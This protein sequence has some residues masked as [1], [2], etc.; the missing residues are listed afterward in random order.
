VENR[1]WAD[2]FDGHPGSPDYVHSRQAVAEGRATLRTLCGEAGQP[3]TVIMEVQGQWTRYAPS[4]SDRIIYDRPKTPAGG[5]PA[6]A[7]ETTS[8]PLAL[9]TQKE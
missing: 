2:Q 7:I 3:V 5:E 8:A 4:D 9:S 6:A 1:N